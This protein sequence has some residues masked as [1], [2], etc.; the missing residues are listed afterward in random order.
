[1]RWTRW[2]LAALGILQF[3]LIWANPQWGISRETAFIFLNIYL[4]AA[5]I[6]GCCGW[7]GYGCGGYCDWDDCDCDHCGDCSKGDCCGKCE[8][9]DEGHAGHEG[10]EG[11][12]H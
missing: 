2:A 11:H 8:C 5:A 10:H 12:S 9:T 3:A 4:I 7:G 6:I 1:M